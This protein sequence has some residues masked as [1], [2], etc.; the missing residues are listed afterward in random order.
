MASTF[1]Y[2]F[3]GATTLDQAWF[4]GSKITFTRATPAS[5]TFFDSAG[6]LQ[7]ASIDQARFDHTL[8]SPF[9]A[10]GL[11]I[12][13]ART[14]RALHNRD[15][16]DAVWVESNITSA[17]DATGLDNVANSA[18]TL[19]A[20]AANGTTLQTVTNASAERTTMEQ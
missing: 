16:T 12:E 5:G 4:E 1:H 8:A 19:T 14:N 10:L 3:A 2:Q 18:S 6:V 15:F 11:L 9:T 7:T 13:E 20:G 17:Q